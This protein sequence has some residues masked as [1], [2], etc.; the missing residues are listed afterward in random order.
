MLDVSNLE[1]LVLDEADRMLDM[2]FVDD[3]ERI[4]QQASKIKQVMSF[5]ATVTSELRDLLHQHIGSDYASIKMQ[6]EVVVSKIDHSFMMVNHGSK[7]DMLDKYLETHRDQKVVIFVQM[8]A[9]TEQLQENLR[10][11]GHEAYALHGDMRQYDRNMTI[12]AYKN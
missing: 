2:G 7:V 10:H 9:H 1:Y 3:V 12:K 6:T 5:S 8:K 11:L 4:R